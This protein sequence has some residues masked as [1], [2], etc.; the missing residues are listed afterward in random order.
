M[1]TEHR[2]G[3]RYCATARSGM[4]CYLANPEGII[5]SEGC[6]A[7]QDGMRAVT[8]SEIPHLPGHDALPHARARETTAPDDAAEKICFILPIPRPFVFVSPDLTIEE[9]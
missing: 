7:I 3:K 2:Q 6:E 4:H 8:W 5:M 1:Q 9:H